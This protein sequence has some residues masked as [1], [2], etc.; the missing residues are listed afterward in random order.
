MKKI[1]KR[2]KVN[3]SK[4]FKFE[5]WLNQMIEDVRNEKP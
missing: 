4:R 1:L 3:L 5:R 2:R